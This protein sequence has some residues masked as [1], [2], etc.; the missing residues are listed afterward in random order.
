MPDVQMAGHCPNME[1]MGKAMPT[2][3]NSKNQPSWGG[4]RP[5][6]GRPKGKANKATLARAAVKQAF[7]DRVAANADRLFNFQMTLAQGVTYLFKTHTDKDGKRS[8]PELVDSEVEIASYLNG[9]YEDSED[10]YYFITTERPDNKA[11][12][13]MLD[14]AFGKAPQK[15]EHS[16]PDG[17]PIAFLDMSADGSDSDS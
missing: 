4:T 5:G 13:S 7:E 10:D 11:I 1:V 6:S 14:R 17:E 3:D 12:D 15:L 2:H 16:G 8:K 9:E